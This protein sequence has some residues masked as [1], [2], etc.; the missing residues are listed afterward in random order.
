MWENSAHCGWHHSLGKGSETILMNELSLAQTNKS[1]Y[2]HS[3][4]CAL[5]YGCD[6]LPDW[7]SWFDLTRIHYHM[8]L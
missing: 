4:L 1:S 2:M 6:W 8:E 7:S 5:D 3:F